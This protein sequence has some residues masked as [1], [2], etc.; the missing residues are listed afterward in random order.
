MLVVMLVASPCLSAR[1]SGPVDGGVDCEAYLAPAI[2]VLGNH[3]FPLH[4]LSGD[5][6]L[7]VHLHILL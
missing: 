5:L 3:C 7:V 6:L 2:D 4:L 1:L